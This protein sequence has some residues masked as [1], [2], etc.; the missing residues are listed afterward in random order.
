MRTILSIAIISVLAGNTPAQIDFVQDV[1][2]ILQEHCYACHGEK[3]QKSGLRLDIK[4]EAFR[5]GDGWGPSIVAGDPGQSPLLE[6]VQSEQPDTRMPPEGPPLSPQHIATLETWI[7]EG[8]KW[9][10]DA[11]TAQLEDKLD[12]WSFKPRNVTRRHATIDEFIDAALTVNGLE[13]NPPAQPRSLVRRMYLD[14]TGL[15]P[16]PAEVADFVETP[17]V[18]QLAD[19]LLASPRYGERWA[20]HWLDVI[21]WAETV[22][23]ETNSERRDA[24]HYRDW[25]IDALNQDKPYD[26]FIF[27]QIAGDCVGEDAALG[28]LVAGPA[29]LPGQIGRDE[30]AMRGARQDELSEVISTVSQAFMGLTVGCARCHDHKFDPIS[31][32]DYYSMQALF[33][34]LRY[35]TRRLRGEQNDAMAAKVPA[36]QAEVKVLVAELAAIRERL[37][38]RAPI[39]DIHHESFPP[40]TTKIVRMKINATNNGSPAALYEFEVWKAPNEGNDSKSSADTAKENVALASRGAQVSASSFALANQSRHHDNLIDGSTD[41]RQAYPWIAGK[42]GPAWLQV[43]FEVPAEISAIT[44]HRGTSMPVDFTVEAQRPDG[45]WLELIHTRDRFPRTD[46]T[47]AAEKLDIADTEQDRQKIAQLL[48]RIR[49]AQAQ[50]ARLRAGPQVYAASFVESPD[51]TFLL[52]R[53]D[54]MQP[55]SEVPPSV[56]LFLEDLKLATDAPDLKRRLALAKHLCS[57]NHPLTARVIVNRVWQHHFG[58][59]LVDTPSDFGRMGSEPTHPELLDWLATKFIEDGW[60]IKK[61]HRRILL[62]K[63]YQQS[64]EPQ[65]RALAVDADCRLLWRFPPRRLEAETL[66]DS[67]LS[68]SGKLNFDAGGRGFSFFNQRGGLSDYKPKETFDRDGL[69]RMI[70]AHKVRM[71]D[72]DVFGPFDC[73]DAG[74]MKPS[75]T[76]S[77]TPVQ[78]LGLL[79]SPFVLRQAVFFAERI[80]NTAGDDVTAQVTLA[81]QIAYAREPTAAE[82]E[83]LVPFVSDHGLDQLCRAILNTSEFAYIQ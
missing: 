35:G 52:R 48:A 21:R 71:I 74:Q 44:L 1:R 5:G 73:P 55:A 72:V 58:K 8:A 51:A 22:G 45:S 3:K 19:K 79:N 61:L 29:N 17:D 53:G 36:A 32:Q 11:D 9:P 39:K 80:E 60:S 56:P 24:W 69:R 16:T 2:P 26:Q 31:Q 46:D 15:P 76:R 6:L 7:R 27:E 30:A 18:R 49:S 43:E 67:I 13:Q 34:G 64:S 81:F 78:S 23:F 70:Y 28:F 4:S 68:A 47:R 40:V 20:Q 37:S 75:R 63:T 33:A 50:L 59:G 82:L 83:R 57:P 41:T 14:V 62:S 65:Q 25:V 42:G 38:L 54:A 12:H 77:I 66:R 10:E